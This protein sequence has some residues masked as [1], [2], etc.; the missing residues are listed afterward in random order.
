MLW[1][2][3]SLVASWFHQLASSHQVDSSGCHFIRIKVLAQT[4]R[5]HRLQSN[6]VNALD[7]FDLLFGCAISNTQI[8]KEQ[9]MLI[10]S[11]L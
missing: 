8:C 3:R 9:A 6:F 11:L 5:K 10:K 2:E 7:I 1:L 4:S